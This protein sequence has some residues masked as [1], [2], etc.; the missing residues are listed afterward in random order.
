M[1]AI[2]SHIATIQ[3]GVFSK[4]VAK[5]DVVYLQARHFDE[6]GE[7][8]S[9]LHPD[10]QTSK[11]TEKHLLQPGDVLFAAKGTKNFAAVYESQNPA[12]V[13]STTFFVIR[14]LDK[15]ILPAYLA[16]MLNN[17]AA[18]KVLKGSA[19]GSA[20]V[21]ISKAVLEALEITVPSIKQQQI[22]LEIARL[23]KKENSLLLQLAELRQQYVQH[24]I[25]KAI[26]K[27]NG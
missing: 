27:S 16:W 17:P 6:S 13:A 22:I 19:I 8:T 14:L 2:L 15:T 26:D 4:S 1:K 18:Q 7:L 3:T 10:L 24:Q 5:G 12:A 23:S 9:A 11:T 20:M 25:I 21:S